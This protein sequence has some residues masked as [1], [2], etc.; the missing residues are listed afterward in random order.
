[1]GRR[2]IAIGKMLLR[3]S[4]YN[5]TDLTIYWVDC[6]EEKRELCLS[7]GADHWIDFKTCKDITAEIKRLTGGK[8]AHAAVV[9]TASVRF[10]SS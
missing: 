4:P 5:L 6:G 2:V 10:L 7:L 9:T 1:M 3:S 8:G